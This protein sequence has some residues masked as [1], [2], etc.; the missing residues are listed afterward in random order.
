[1]KIN[2]FAEMKIRFLYLFTVISNKRKPIAGPMPCGSSSGKATF[3]ADLY[4]FFYTKI[5]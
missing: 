4:L 3:M 2:F 1:M 5:V